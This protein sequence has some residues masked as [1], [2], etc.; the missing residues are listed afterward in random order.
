MA[1]YYYLI[2]SL[3]EL[4]FEA[5]HFKNSDFLHLRDY[6]LE[7]ISDGDAVYVHDLLG[8]IDNYNLIA[9]V[10][11]KRRAW[12]KGGKY[13]E[14][15]SPDDSEKPVLPE[16]MSDFL[17]YIDSY[18]AEYKTNPDEPAAEKYLSE[19]YY[20][21]MES[22]DNPFIAKW[23]KFDREM[24][25]IQ[26]A[27]TGRRTGISAENYFVK[28]D[29]ITE[30]LLKN[31]SPDFGLSRERD[32]VPDLFRALETPNLLERENR[33]DMLRWNQIDEINIMEYFSIDVALGILQKACIADRWL[34]LDSVE[35][36]KM[37]RK[38]VDDLI[39]FKKVKIV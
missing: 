21:K 31:A 17:E 36:K 7:N 10:Y 8:N 24:K 39:E 30:F 16:Y 22:S 11:G 32:Y 29:D 3:P 13:D 12:K 2:S 6:I 9:A 25:N 38:L 15:R 20:D 26:T 4:F 5:G 1:K 33:L 27:Y 23:F 35:G 28:K 37:F 18:K 34:A 14:F 19:L